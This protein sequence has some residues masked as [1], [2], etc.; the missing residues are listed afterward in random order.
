[1]FRG[2]STAKGVVVEQDVDTDRLEEMTVKELMDLKAAV[3][4]AI[5][6]SIARDRLARTQSVQSAP[7][8]DLERE[9]DAWTAS[10]KGT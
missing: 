9:R 4:A 7:A 5:R 2:A 3:D 1:M 6:A 10:R 8:V